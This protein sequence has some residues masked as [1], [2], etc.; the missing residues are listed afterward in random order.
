MSSI[1]AEVAGPSSTVEAQLVRNPKMDQWICWW[2]LPIFYNLFG[3]IFVYLGKIMPPPK[4]GLTQA[5]IVAFVQ[6]N[7]KNMQIAWVLLALL[8]GFA[9]LSSGLIVTHM[10]RM[11]GVS[12][13]LTYTY[14]A[15]L[16]VAAL[17]GCL[18]CSLMFAL[19]AFRP[20]RDPQLVALLYDMGMLSFVGSLGCF[21]TQYLV[22]AIAIFLDKRG[23]FP[24]WLAYMS[25]WGLVTELVAMPIWIFRDGPYAWDGLISFYLGTIIFVTWEFCL[26]VCLYKAI[27]HQPLEELAA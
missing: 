21:V 7:A 24:K 12:A 8:L 9:S 13:A 26:I 14:L 19:A 25:I 4:P 11:T 1:A 23:I 22:F 17:P 2:S 15:A 3:L 20:D 6:S 18:F 5:E 27:K 16:A 10:K